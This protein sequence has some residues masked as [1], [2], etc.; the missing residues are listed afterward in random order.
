MEDSA[1]DSGGI[2]CP[3]AAETI[4][5]TMTPERKA[6]VTISTASSDI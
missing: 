6:A 5:P 3:S 1:E 4:Y 2:A